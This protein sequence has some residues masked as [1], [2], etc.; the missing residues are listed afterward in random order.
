MSQKYNG[1][2]TDQTSELK[3]SGV[4]K[5]DNKL[6]SIKSESRSSSSK[7]STPHKS[8]NSSSTNKES[9]SKTLREAHGVYCTF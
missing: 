2:K 3:T 8:S 5:S 9:S 6:K 7:G 1:S 4:S